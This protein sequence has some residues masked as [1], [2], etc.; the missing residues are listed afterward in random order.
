MTED[1]LATHTDVQH[2]RTGIATA[3]ENAERLLEGVREFPPTRGGDGREI[4]EVRADYAKASEPLG[5]IPLPVTGRAVF[6]P[7]TQ[8]FRSIRPAQFIDKLGERLTFERSSGRLYQ[9]A[10][11]KLDAFGSFNGGP[12]RGELEEMMLKELDHFRLL[13]DVIENVGSDP[14]VL[15]PSADLYATMSR[16]V[17]DVLV[18]ARTSFADCLE[19][20]LLLELVDNE[21][22]EMLSD[23]AQQNG[24][25]TLAR[26]FE[27]VRNTESAHLDGVRAWL[28]AAHN[29][30]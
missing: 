9:A 26:L 17:V 5:T 6:R 14:T 22:W 12:S 10:I 7:V 2:N 3:K 19:G 8:G 16:G 4:L 21:G 25:S 13:S 30:A 18:D 15:T 23:L 29:R 20:L 27:S 1:G 11:S 28:A 24:E